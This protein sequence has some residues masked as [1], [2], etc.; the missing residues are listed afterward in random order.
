MPRR[1]VSSAIL[2][3][4][5]PSFPCLY[6]P[7]EWPLRKH[8][9][10]QPTSHMSDPLA[11][12]VSRTEQ[13]GWFAEEVLP[14]EPTLR[15]YLYRKFPALPDVDDVVQE[16]YLRL[17]RAR[18][19]GSLRSVKGFLFTTARNVAFDVFRRSRTTSL[20]AVVESQH[21]QLLQDGPG[22]AETVSHNHELALLAEAIETLPPGCRRIMKL[23]KIYEHSHKEIAARLGISERT[24]NV[25]VG[26][27]VRR[28]VEYLQARGVVSDGSKRNRTDHV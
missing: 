12:Q 1:T 24:V 14:Y 19:A 10:C 5:A 9:S 6:P 20:E 18:A 7:A 17:L 8:E 4:F 15:A 16:S 11:K 3:L 26:K 2:P 28:C 13:S 25:Q 27:G 21:L 23:R 22:V